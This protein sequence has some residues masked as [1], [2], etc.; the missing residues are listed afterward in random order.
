MV[1]QG[2]RSQTLCSRCPGWDLKSPATSH[3]QCRYLYEWPQ[4]GKL[5]LSSTGEVLQLKDIQT[6]EGSVSG[7]KTCNEGYHE[8]IPAL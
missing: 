8:R 3:R 6:R 7:A 2:S 5:R 4:P 1:S